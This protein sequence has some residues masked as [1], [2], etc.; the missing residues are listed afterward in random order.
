MWVGR[1]I[2]RWQ[3]INATG[4]SRSFSLQR[5]GPGVRQN[6]TRAAY[7]VLLDGGSPNTHGRLRATSGSSGSGIPISSFSRRVFVLIGHACARC[8]CLPEMSKDDLPIRRLCDYPERRM[9]P[10][11]QAPAWW[12]VCARP[13]CPHLKFSTVTKGLGRSTRVSS[14]TCLSAVSTTGRDRQFATLRVWVYLSARDEAR[15]AASSVQQPPGIWRYWSPH[16]ISGA[17]REQ[18]D[19]GSEICGAVLSVRG[20]E[21]ILSLWNKSATEG[22]IN[23]QIRYIESTF[24]VK[25]AISLI[26]CTS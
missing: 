12:S 16:R 22:R 8:L 21:D 23:H 17:N 9:F 3:A 4:A 10:R 19:V 14:K 13:S 5:Q 11:T 18:F 7:A 24:H 15:S 6:V 26:F 20:S 25:V 1:A 2:S